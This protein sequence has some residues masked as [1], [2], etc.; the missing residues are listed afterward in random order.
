M[1]RWPL[2]HLGAYGGGDG[3]CAAGLSAIDGSRGRRRI[4]REAARRSGPQH[5]PPDRRRLSAAAFPLLPPSAPPWIDSQLT[6]ALKDLPR[7]WALLL[8]DV[9]L[10]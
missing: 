6:R 10:D 1:E 5:W 2:A 9:I 4:I 8:D 7:A 3:S